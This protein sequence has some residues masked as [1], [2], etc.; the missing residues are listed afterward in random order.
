MPDP[1][2]DV[3]LPTPATLAETDADAVAAAD[4][5]ATD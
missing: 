3:A 2:T 1:T 5:F 4:T